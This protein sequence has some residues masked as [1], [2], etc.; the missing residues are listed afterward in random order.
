VV[1]TLLI[2]TFSLQPLEPPSVHRSVERL[3]RSMIEKLGKYLSNQ[4]ISIDDEPGA[5]VLSPTNDMAVLFRRR[6]DL[7]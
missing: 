2:G 6:Q 4:Q 5:A 3:E 7:V 1:V